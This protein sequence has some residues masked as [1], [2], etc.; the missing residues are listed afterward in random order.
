MR[1]E[2]SCF[3]GFFLKYHTW[4]FF[5][6]FNFS[7]DNCSTPYIIVIHHPPIYTV[8]YSTAAAGMVPE[9]PVLKT[10]V[11]TLPAAGGRVCM[12]QIFTGCTSLITQQQHTRTNPFFQV[13]RYI[14][15]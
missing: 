14:L 15:C 13:F 12:V 4:H 11:R 3:P 6:T 5:Q 1:L 7:R 8:Q 9:V 10:T 2:S